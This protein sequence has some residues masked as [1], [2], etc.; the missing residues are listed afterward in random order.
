[1][2]P[3]DRPFGTYALC[4][5]GAPL[6]VLA[7]LLLASCDSPA[8]PFV[9]VA[10]TVTVDQAVLSFTAL[11]A[12]GALVATVRDQSG[13][14]MPSAAVSWRSL[15]KGVAIVSSSGI[16]TAAGVGQTR[17]VAIAGEA[18]ASVSVTVAQLAA[19]I[20][21][22][23]DSVAFESPGDTLRLVALV[24]DSGGTEQAGASP[25]W[26][27]SDTV[28]A[29]VTD[30]GLV[31]AV[32]TGTATILVGSGTASA[33]VYVRV[34][35]ELMLTAASSQL[36]TAEVATSVSLSVRVEDPSG[37]PYAG[38]SVTWSA[39]A[40][41]AI[42]STSVTP[43]DE[44]GHASAVWQ[45][46][47]V[48]GSHVAT[49]TIT[50]R[51]TTVAVAFTADALAAPASVA[52]L[53]SD[54]VLLS[55]RG[56][57]AFLGPTFEDPYGNAATPVPMSWTSRDPA[58]A[59]VASDGLIVAEA[60][61]AA[62]VTGSLGA[63]VD[64]VL[65][66]VVLRGAITISFD[67]GWLTT[68]TDARSVMDEYGF[69]GNIAVYTE[70]VDGGFPAYMDADQLQ[71]LHDAGWTLVSHT[72]SHDSLSTLS[73]LELDAELRLSQ[74]WLVDRGFERGSDVII[75]PYHDF[76]GRERVAASAYYEVAR[77][78]SANAVVP[79]S[80]VY[81]QPT[82]PY[83]LTGIDAEQLPYTT[84]AGR[85]RLRAMLQRTRDEGRFLDVFFHQVPPANVDALR[86]TLAV[87][88]EFRD[89]V[90]PYHELYPEL[91]RTVN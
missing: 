71:E 62:W 19:S 42:T 29:T 39:P 25:T 47:T 79:D 64:S 75:V 52:Y 17:V 1:M 8:G 37:Q 80:M 20:E 18:S 57:T 40:G 5:R 45:L 14:V 28:V 23:A 41:S 3:L 55:G 72:V 68:Y 24:R 59:T 81:W 56:E 27:S 78:A 7:C 2:L 15:D 44:T 66:T 88:D 35:P 65:V 86:E 43:S 85:D 48:A 6:G 91:A 33:L 84:V 46:G 61:G 38:A 30:G 63:A 90:L 12:S 26:T 89:R 83:E 36:V 11:S 74:R 76:G 87:I 77:G 9:P 70:V 34:L 50:T 54:S 32:G 82:N 53:V 10:T 58:V 51:G 22:S 67:D 49:A 16:V 4:R 21:L 31:T 69:A 13:D 73:D 60:A